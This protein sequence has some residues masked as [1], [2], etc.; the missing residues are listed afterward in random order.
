MIALITARAAAWQRGSVHRQVL[1]AA[2]V[3]AFFTFAAKLAAA[4]KEIVVAQRFGT[5]TDVDAFI[6]AM[7]V[8]GF[9]MSV[10]ASSLRTALIP[11]YV[12]V[13]E[14]EGAD[15][16]QRLLSSTM[17]L[18]LALMTVAAGLI[19][20]L[21]P[22]TLRLVAR[23]LTSDVVQLTTRLSFWILPGIV[24]A[25]ANT[26]WSAVLHAHQ[27]FT[28]PSAAPLAMP[29]CAVGALLAGGRTWGIHALAAG[30]LLGWVVESAWI[31]VA[32]RREGLTLLP[33]WRGMTPAVRRVAGQYWPM[34]AGT[35]VMGSNPVVDNVMAAALGAGSVAALGYGGKVNS[36][37]LGVGASSVAAAVLPHFSRLAARRDWAGLLR[38]TRTYAA[39]LIGISI[40]LTIALVALSTPIARLLF[41]RGAF[42]AADTAVVSRIQTFYFVATPIGFAGVLFVRLIIATNATQFLMWLSILNAIVNVTANL[43]FSR[44]L[45]VAGIALSTSLVSVLSPLLAFAYASRRLRTLIETGG[46]P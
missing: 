40:P 35:L 17:V 41:E 31:G 5:S 36:L 22:A 6:L 45:G 33:R 1:S 23:G 44:W 11:T 4:A 15:A 24:L 29:V 21:L 8:P 32:V 27:K 16:A 25:G 7:I 14:Q 9:A 38:T 46:E 28:V 43:A 42:T 39:L 20:T 3:V 10:V 19:V 13:R 34:V 2:A 26:I 37:I 18:G 12:D 30:T